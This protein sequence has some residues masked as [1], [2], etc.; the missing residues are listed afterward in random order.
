MLI[1][2]SFAMTSNFCCWSP[3]TFVSPAMPYLKET[4]KQTFHLLKEFTNSNPVPLLI[5]HNSCNQSAIVLQGLLSH[6]AC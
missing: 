4:K 3:D 5:L 6:T 2:S 1:N